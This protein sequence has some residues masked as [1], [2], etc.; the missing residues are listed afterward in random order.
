MKIHYITF[1]LGLLSL[2]AC[3]KYDNYEKPGMTLKGVLTDSITGK[4]LETEVGDN[5]V[6]FRMLDLSY[7]TH[8]T[9]WYFTSKQNG[10]YECSMVPRGTY[11]V[12]PLGAFVPLVLTDSNGDTTRN[13]SVTADINGTVTQDFTV[14]PFLV[15]SW[16]GTPVVNADKT[17]TV[18]FKVERGT[19]DP[20]FQQECTNIYLYV[21]SSS[22]NVGDNNYDSRYTVSVSNPNSVLGQT[23]TVTTPILPYSGTKYYLRAGARINYSVEG[24][25][26]YNYNEAIAVDVP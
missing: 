15:L 7:T 17:I 21:N 26:R 19:T 6:R 12:L 3:K 16:V 23:L 9:A 14:V 25:N 4:G 10:E 18:Q 5:G 2:A 13:G 24:T 8:P 1:I 20:A 11:N 22:Y